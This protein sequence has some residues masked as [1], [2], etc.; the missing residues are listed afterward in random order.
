MTAKLS[1]LRSRALI[2]VRGPDWRGFLQGLLTQDVE[3]LAEGECRYG[4]LLTPQ[5]RLL[6]DM[7]LFGEAGGGGVLLDVP[8]SERHAV[9]QRLSLYR[10]R[11]KVEIGL[12][13]GGVFALWDVEAPGAGWAADPRLAELGWRTTG[14]EA[15]MVAGA[16]EVDEDAYEARR[17][18]LGASDAYRD[19]LQ[20]KTYPVEANLDLLNGIDFKKGCFV[21][22]ET[23]SRMK[24]RGQIRTRLVPILFEGAAPAPGT[25]V[26]AG[27]LRAGQVAG[28]REGRALALLRLDRL[29]AGPLSVDGRPARADPPDWMPLPALGSEDD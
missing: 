19:G 29:A 9:A 2:S 21:G 1:H 13:E 4:A 22:Q 8:A 6:Y 20:D 23:T 3:T 24:R 28:G 5:G 18:A 15:P 11:A 10:L 17:L 26:L 25:E 16:E 14:L 12:A 27:E 7:F